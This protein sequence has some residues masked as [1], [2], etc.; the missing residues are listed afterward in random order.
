MNAHDLSPESRVTLRLMIHSRVAQLRQQDFGV[1]GPKELQRVGD[2]IDEL[3]FDPV[4]F[5]PK[6]ENAT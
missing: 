3:G 6:N 2:L 1:Y 4:D 5:A